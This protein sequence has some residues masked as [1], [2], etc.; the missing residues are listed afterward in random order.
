M[1]LRA[2]GGMADR[3]FRLQS[4]GNYEFVNLRLI[5]SAEHCA[6]RTYYL[7]I[8][9]AGCTGRCW[10]RHEESDNFKK[11]DMVAVAKHND[12]SLQEGVI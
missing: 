8:K 6:Q 3:L 11:C 10:N 12:R 5:T 9:V 4:Y 2:L 7:H 1:P